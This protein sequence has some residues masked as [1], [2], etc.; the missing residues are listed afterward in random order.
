MGPGLLDFRNAHTI[1][2]MQ[3]SPA[4]DTDRFGFPLV[5]FELLLPAGASAG[6][7]SDKESHMP[8]PPEE[9]RIRSSTLR[10]NA[11][12]LLRNMSSKQPAGTYR[13]DTTESLIGGRLEPVST[14]L[15]LRVGASIRIRAVDRDD[16]F[17]VWLRDRKRGRD[18][19]TAGE[20]A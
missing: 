14:E 11:P 15:F 8:F 3:T 9:P 6:L 16:L 18:S 19:S 2:D 13:V 4:T 20:A 17:T 10:F 7:H 1:W 12:F 5:P